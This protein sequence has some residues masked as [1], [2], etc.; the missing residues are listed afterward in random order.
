MSITFSCGQCGKVFTL[1]DK[2][3]GKKGKCKQCGSMMQIPDRD[4]EESPVPSRTEEGVSLRARPTSGAPH[5]QASSGRSDS[6][7]VPTSLEEAPIPRRSK[8]PT[9]AIHDIYGLDD[10]PLPPRSPSPGAVNP[11]ST[12]TPAPTANRKKKK[13]TGFFGGGGR[14]SSSSSSGGFLSIDFTSGL[15][16][17]LLGLF[18]TFI[19]L[20][21]FYALINGVSSRSSIETY[22]RRQVQMIDEV[23]TLLRPINDRE[24]AERASTVVNQKLRSLTK[25]TRENM[26]LKARK[27][28]IE[29]LTLQYEPEQ[30]RASTAMVQELQ[31]LA[32]IDGA[33]QA[34]NI[35]AAI[36]EGAAVDAEIQRLRLQNQQ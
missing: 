36:D 27:R 21:G 8:E 6:R 12:S 10:E 35:E 32:N 13:S 19:V 24:G 31:R 20:P 5:R 15:P 22:Y 14:K 29:S 11:D 34:L 25:Y 30:I 26:N 7:P 16:R 18:I 17:L 4:R 1:D 3:A 9:S 23:T 2:F 33:M 28:D